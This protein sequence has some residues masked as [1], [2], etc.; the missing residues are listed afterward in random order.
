MEN[1][2]FI[3]CISCKFLSEAFIMEYLHENRAFVFK[4]HLC[5]LFIVS[6]EITAAVCDIHRAFHIESTHWTMN[7]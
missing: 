3:F 7:N 4:V 1:I 5:L 2:L 6:P